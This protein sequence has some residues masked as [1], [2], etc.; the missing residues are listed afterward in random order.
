M[1]TAF[2]PQTDGQTELMNAGMEQYLWV[3]NN[4]QEDDWVQF[5]PLAE[6]A[7]NNGMSESTKCTP[8]IAVQGVDPLMSFD[9]EPTQER[10]QRR[11]EADQLQAT[12]QQVYEHLRVEMRRSQTIQAE[13]AN[14]ECI[15]ARNI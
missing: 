1:S 9:G 11:C 15:P 13:G 2:H 5:L 3:F 12:M 4:H 6:F 14:R 10:A 7:A 8:F